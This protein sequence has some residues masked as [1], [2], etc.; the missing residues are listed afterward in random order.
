MNA[1]KCKCGQLF[2][3]QGHEGVCTGKCEAC[4]MN[5]IFEMGFELQNMDHKNDT[6]NKLAE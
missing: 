4:L 2:I 6:S 1:I 3:C 5:S